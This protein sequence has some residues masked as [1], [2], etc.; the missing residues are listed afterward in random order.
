[1][2]AILTGAKHATP[3]PRIVDPSEVKVESGIPFPKTRCRPGTKWGPHLDKMKKG[4]CI[5]FE[6]MRN[7]NIF[8]N[9]AR[10][11]DQAK[12]TVQTIRLTN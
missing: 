7:A 1:M 6:D 5:K 9:A 3:K 4:D 2:S 10:A 12:N 11:V 8:A